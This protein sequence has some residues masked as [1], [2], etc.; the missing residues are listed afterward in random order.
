MKIFQKN[1]SLYPNLFYGILW[2]V[3]GIYR[4]VSSDKGVWLSSAFIVISVLY[5]IQFF[6]FFIKPVL[7]IENNQIVWND[8]FR[9]KIFGLDDIER[10][11][12]FA[13]DYTIFTET[14][15]IKIN[16]QVFEKESLE[17]LNI[18]LENLH[19]ENLQ[20]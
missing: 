9:S 12:K 18:I 19:L 10:V 1:R 16:T 8:L 4:I 7:I 17:K 13:G 11:K 6:Y 5:L 20:N 14:D 3:Y 15:K 2:L